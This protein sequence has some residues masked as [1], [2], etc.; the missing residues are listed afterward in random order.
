M[1]ERKA[2]KNGTSDLSYVPMGLIPKFLKEMAI[3][4]CRNCNGPRGHG[5]SV[6][7]FDIDRNGKKSLK[8]SKAECMKDV[9]EFIDFTFPVQGDALQY[10][11]ISDGKFLPF[12]D[13]PSSALVAVKKLKIVS[14]SEAVKKSILSLWPILLINLQFTVL[15]GLIYWILVRDST[16]KIHH[17]SSYCRNINVLGVDQR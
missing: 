11:F 5:T 12:M 16:C 6:V 8:K 1:N 3:W 9:D 7:H 4:G 13:H 2:I 17:F 10:K 15:S 14:K